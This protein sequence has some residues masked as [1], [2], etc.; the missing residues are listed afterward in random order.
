MSFSLDN[1]IEDCRNALKET[2]SRSAVAELTEAVISSPASILQSLGTPTLAGLQTLYH[3]P[4]LTILNITW[5]PGMTLHPHNHCMWAVI[6]I[7]GGSE[8]NTFYRRSA[9]GLVEHGKK[10][11]EVGHA[12]K[13]GEDVIHSVHNPESKLT[14]ALHVYD[15]DFFNAHRSEW[16]S[17]TLVE[18]AYDIEHAKAVFAAANERL[19]A[20]N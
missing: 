6:G 12:A 2:D 11:L 20:A 16:D 9:E 7:Y 10:T 8:E 13:L 15:G 19:A 3:A 14:T 1:Y 5:A 17:E 4:D 18:Q